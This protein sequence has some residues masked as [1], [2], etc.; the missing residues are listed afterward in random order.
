M[1]WIRVAGRMF[2]GCWGP[3]WKALG[4]CLTLEVEEGLGSQGGVGGAAGR[5]QPLSVVSSVSPAFQVGLLQGLCSA[6]GDTKGNVI[7]FHL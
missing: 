5:A 1:V 2:G 6:Y 3:G 4:L 7:I